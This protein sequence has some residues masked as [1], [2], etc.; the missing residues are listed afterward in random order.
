MKKITA[1]I[2]SLALMGCA[3][4]SCGGKDGDKAESRLLPKAADTCVSDFSKDVFSGNS[5][6]MLACMYPDE[7]VSGL[8][9][10][11]LMDQLESAMKSGADGSF[12]SCS[13]SGEVKLSDKAL[14]GAG[15]YFDAYAQMLNISAGPYKVTDG[16]K[17]K[18]TVVTTESGKDA[19]FDEDVIVVNVDGE[20]WK[21]IPMD[22]ASLEAAA[23]KGNG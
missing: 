8:K 18:M 14:Q 5:D 7:L 12:K 3:A 19:P 17:L 23:D 21:L 22:E 20:G 6:D 15:T 4:V 9:S 16:Y 11:G 2:L 1:T 13:T 10:S